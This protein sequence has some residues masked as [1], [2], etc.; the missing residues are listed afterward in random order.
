LVFW[1]GFEGFGAFVGAGFAPVEVEAATVDLVGLAEN[2]IVK[3]QERIMG[4][5]LMRNY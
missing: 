3:Q 4:L 1:R 2:R 5:A